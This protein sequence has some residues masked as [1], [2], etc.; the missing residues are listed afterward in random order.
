M[1]SQTTT[2]TAAQLAGARALAESGDAQKTRTRARLSL[3]DLQRELRQRGVD[4]PTSNLS[5]WERGLVRPRGEEAVRWAELIG[6]LGALVTS[7]RSP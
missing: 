4:V 5:L 2:F 3:R 1:R 6:E 7:E